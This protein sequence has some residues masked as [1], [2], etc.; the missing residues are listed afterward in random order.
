MVYN[1][2]EYF[3]ATKKLRILPLAATW[4]ELEGVILS[5]MSDRERQIPYK[6]NCMQN[7]KNKTNKTKQKQAHR[8][9]KET[10]GYQR[11]ERLEGE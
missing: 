6:F 2:M 10:I 7:L 5:K 1:M 3:S 8:Y 9:R 11:G 4:I